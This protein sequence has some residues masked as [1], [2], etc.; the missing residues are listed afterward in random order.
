VKPKEDSSIQRNEAFSESLVWAIVAVTVVGLGVTIGLMSVM[1]KVVNFSNDII[2]AFTALCFL[3]FIAVDIVFIWLLLRPAFSM[4]RIPN[5]S[6]E[7]RT[8]HL[9]ELG[10]RILPEASPTVTEHT[11]RTLEKAET[12]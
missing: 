5:K 2:L 1:K 7:L 10:P 12:K 3:S 9:G 6:Q 11:T 4:R 8:T